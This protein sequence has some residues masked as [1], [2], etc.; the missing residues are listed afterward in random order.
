MG[1][2]RGSVLAPECGACF[3]VRPQSQGALPAARLHRFKFQ[4]DPTGLE[5]TLIAATEGGGPNRPALHLQTAAA[6]NAGGD[7][8]PSLA[9]VEGLHFT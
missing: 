4:S 6:T 1:V 7:P 2:N 9:Q 5:E 3:G 8:S